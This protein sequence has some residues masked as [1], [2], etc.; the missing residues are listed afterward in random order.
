MKFYEIFTPSRVE[1]AEFICEIFILIFQAEGSE[2]FS[3][4][5]TRWRE[6]SREAEN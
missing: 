3:L 5:S 4:P 1:C 2:M 6:M